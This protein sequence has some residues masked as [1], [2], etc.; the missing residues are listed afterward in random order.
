MEALFSQL[1]A[2]AQADEG[3]PPPDGDAHNQQQRGAGG[4]AVPAPL[5]YLLAEPLLAAL[6]AGGADGQTGHEGSP[7]SDDGSEEWGASAL[8]PESMRMLQLLRDACWPACGL[9]IANAPALVLPGR[10]RRAAAAG[11]ETPP[12]PLLL[13][14]QLAEP[15]VRFEGLALASIVYRQLLLRSAGADADELDHQGAG[16]LELSVY[17]IV[18]L[19]A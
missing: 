17:I 18:Y 13:P 16:R 5:S 6:I 1:E 12:R 2:Q 11:R 9:A 7:G 3:V 19:H 4:L 10:G 15:V 8:H 14:R